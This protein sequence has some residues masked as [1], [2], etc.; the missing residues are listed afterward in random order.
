M[1]F[2]SRGSPSAGRVDTRETT[3]PS[4]AVLENAFRRWVTET[5]HTDLMHVDRDSDLPLVPVLK[6]L[7]TSTQPLLPA[8]AGILGLPDHASLGDAASQLLHAHVDPDGP[9]CRSLRSALWY[10]QGLGRLEEIEA[11]APAWSVE[12]MARIRRPDRVAHAT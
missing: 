8:D 4:L 10:L 7:R 9:R 6:Q 2:R 5:G 1:F 3:G 12:V 11:A